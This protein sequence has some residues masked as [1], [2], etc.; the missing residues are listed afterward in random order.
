MEPSQRPFSVEGASGS[1]LDAASTPVVR[2]RGTA[3]TGTSGKP[4]AAGQDTLG[5]L[6]AA[7]KP[8]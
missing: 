6:E 8:L 4:F 1:W 3:G 7:S 5:W 2:S